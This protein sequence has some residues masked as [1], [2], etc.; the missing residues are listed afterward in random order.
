[1]NSDKAARD[2]LD[3]Q[4]NH[5]RPELWRLAELGDNGDEDARR[6]CLEM[7]AAD[8]VRLA[9]LR[10]FGPHFSEPD[11]DDALDS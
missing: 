1:M 9:I 2:A 7:L 6:R 3:A 10:S 5:D 4:L 11:L 8:E